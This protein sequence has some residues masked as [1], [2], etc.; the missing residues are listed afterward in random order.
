MA[1]IGQ[2]AAGVAHEINNPIGFISSNLHTLGK[3]VDGLLAVVAAYEEH[4]DPLLAEHPAPLATV[5]AVRQGAELHYLRDDL[6][7]LLEETQEGVSRV[8]KIVQDLKDFSHVDAVV[9]QPADLHRGLDSTLNVVW[10]ELKY[11]A[12]VVKEYGT[13]PEIECIASQI[14]QVFMN[15]L[16][17]A[18]HAIDDRGVITLRTGH[19][20]GM[21]WCE[22]A[23]TGHGIPAENLLR[24]FEPFF[25]TKAVGKGTGLGL[26]LSYSIVKKHGGR[27]EVKSEPGRG[28][29]FRVWLPV[30]RP[31]ETAAEA[32]P[33]AV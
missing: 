27:I 31:V 10:N 7:T 13:I 28:S 30:N 18:A 19:E 26:S 6:P 9:W 16:V 33:E 4:A 22:V 24:I 32:V 12:Q 17:N 11:K 15:L 23:D 3:Y 5:K 21:V 1:A 2:L 29:V 20:G 8:S 25:T 14:N